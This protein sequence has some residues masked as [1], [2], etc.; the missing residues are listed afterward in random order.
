MINFNSNKY[1][2][3]IIS[4]NDTLINN[5]YN[6]KYL[7]IILDSKL[8]FKNHII[9]LNN[10][11][12]QIQFL[13]SKL[14]KFIKTN[15]LII[16]YN[17][18]FLPYLNYGNILWGNTFSNN[19]LNTTI[20]QK[21]TLRII[22]KRKF[23]DHTKELFTSNKILRLDKLT[24]YNT[25]I[26]MHKQYY[27]QLPTNLTKIHTKN[28]NKYTLRT[29]KTYTIPISKSTRTINSLLIKGPTLW[30]LLPTNI[31]N[32]KNENLFKKR[33]QNMLINDELYYR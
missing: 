16:I 21:K 3:N 20:I 31:Q 10:K 25:L 18:I 28:N 5:V 13:I 11:L 26:Y 32:I 6:Y 7:G 19:T 12:S 22:N 8:D 27:N 30:N 1:P 14:S 17:S 33:V 24:Y 9:K 4:L 2:N 15:S 23:R 29:N